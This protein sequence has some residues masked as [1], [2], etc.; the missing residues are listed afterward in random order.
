MI[1]NKNSDC[2]KIIYLG[3]QKRSECTVTV[4]SNKLWIHIVNVFFS[5]SFV[6]T[7]FNFFMLGFV[8]MFFG[9][10]SLLFIKESEYK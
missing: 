1:N 10:S 5:S 6:I 4:N 8:S 2:F 3:Y 9:N 7:V